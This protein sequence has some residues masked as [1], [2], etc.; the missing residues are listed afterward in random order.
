MR[1]ACAETTRGQFALPLFLPHRISEGTLNGGRLMQ[2]LLRPLL[3]VVLIGVA[4]GFV[5]GAAIGFYLLPVSYKD[6][7]F[8]HLGSAQKDDWVVMVSAAYALDNNLD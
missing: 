8:A 6:T 5:L 7:D 2:R 3:T 4:T 1:C